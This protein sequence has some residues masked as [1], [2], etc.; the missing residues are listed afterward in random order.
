MHDPIP[1]SEIRNITFQEKLEDISKKSV[2][3]SG[4]SFTYTGKAVK[5]TV[6]V[7][8]LKLNKDYSLDYSNNIN[9]G[10]GYVYVLGMGKYG[11]YKVL[12]FKITPKKATPT[13]NVNSTSFIY[14]MK[15]HVPIVKSVKV[16]KTTI[17]KNSYTVKYSNSKSTKKGSNYK[18]TVT[19]KGNY[20]GSIGTITYK[21]RKGT[22]EEMAN[23]VIAGKWGNNSDRKKRLTK[24]GYNYKKIQNKVNK[25]CAKKAVKKKSKNKKKK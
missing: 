23:Q 24:A 3:L 19:L 20:S 14:D 13:I 2:K 17:N 11:N 4:T 8:G 21:I 16:G 12:S 25:L 9:V 5:P 22:V 10:T 18:V 15:K 7:S 6:T 1:G